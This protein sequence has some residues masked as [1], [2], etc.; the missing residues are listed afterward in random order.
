LIDVKLSSKP[1]C[2]RINRI[3]KAQVKSE[4]RSRARRAAIVEAASF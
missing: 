2:P 1:G 3:V 4:E